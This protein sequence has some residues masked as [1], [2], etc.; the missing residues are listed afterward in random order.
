MSVQTVGELLD[1]AANRWPDA[2][3]LVV[4]D[5]RQWTFTELRATA[6]QVACSLLTIAEPGEHIAVWSPNCAEWYLLQLGAGLAGMTV[7]TVNPAYRAAEVSDVLARS[8]CAAV[9]L[10]AEFRGTDLT[11]V[12]DAVRGELPA[13]RNAVQLRDWE[14][15]LDRAVERRLP[16]VTPQSPA[17][18]QF[19][20]GTTGC[21][22]GAVLPHSAVVENGIRGAQRWQVQAGEVWLNAMPMFHVAGSVINALGA[23]S[24]GAA[25]LICPFD[26][27]ATVKL[28]REH[29]VSVACLGGTMWAMLLDQPEVELTSVRVAIA[30]GQ[31]I[32]PDLVRRVDAAVSGRM[33][34][35]FGMTELC[36]TVTA[37]A[38]DDDEETRA[39]TCGRPLPGVELR[40]VEGEIQA[41]GWLTMTGYFED[42]SAT[43]ATLLESGWLRTGDIGCL[44]ERG[45]LRITGR[46]KEMIIRGAENIYPAEIEI[47][48]RA[49]PAI[50]DAA[51][52][53]LP[54]PV[55]G[56]SVA[57]A[58]VLHSSADVPSDAE[59]QAWCR[60]ELAPFK[61]PKTWTFVDAL[62]MTP[63]GK[64]QK[65][66][67]RELLCG[68]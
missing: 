56:E 33:S 45:R 60:A 41:R 34:I 6:T 7:V 62:P 55:Y 11:D 67:L 25:Q 43:A 64:I 59:L 36:G 53:G 66:R 68:H 9:F 27:V 3:G 17:Q 52:F 16:M 1:A 37:G 51:V 61:T 22:K 4:P 28:I 13:L 14:A 20:S 44:D 54:D 2:L 5:G 23:L 18:I 39:E 65:F 8:R 32:S 40:I 19:T 29:K 50:A 12:L 47:R 31:S 63:S 46:A 49:H 15:F 26:A 57:A 10:A 30:G 58:V 42:P 35:L 38:I 48:L 21:P 24:A